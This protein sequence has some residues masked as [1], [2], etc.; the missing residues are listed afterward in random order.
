M[1]ARTKRVLE[2]ALEL[3]AEDRALVAAAL[4]ASLD[5][6]YEEAEDDATPEEIEQA[7]A[8]EMLE[9]PPP[10][11]AA[12]ISVGEELV[13][14]RDRHGLLGP[15]LED[16]VIDTGA[17]ACRLLVAD[18]EPTDLEDREHGSGGGEEA[19]LGAALDLKPQPLH[20]KTLTELAEVIV[21]LAIARGIP[22]GSC[23]PREHERVALASPP[24]CRTVKA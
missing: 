9:G 17:D 3:S 16:I 4:E 18:G 5:D 2:E 12:W 24:A 6:L 20:P 7:W 8:E 1:N 19:A 10:L 11:F 23:D 14:R 13:S 15:L 21:D 22:T